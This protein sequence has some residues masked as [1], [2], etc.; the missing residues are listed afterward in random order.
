MTVAEPPARE[1]PTSPR[2]GVV[3]G[4][5]AYVA[6]GLVP[7]YFKQVTGV[8]P[9]AVLAHR[10][11]W[12]VAFLSVLVTVQKLWRE[13]MACF[14]SRSLLLAL[15]GSTFAVAI[16]WFTFIFAISTGRILQSSLGYFMTPLVSVALGVMVL[17][18]R[19]R[20]WQLAG[21]VLVVVG[22]AIQVVGTRQ[23]P[24]ISL[25][26]A[27]SFSSYGL[28]RKQMRVGP[29]IGGIV[30]TMLMLPIAI[31]IVALQLRADV[32]GDAH[33][34][35]TYALLPFSGFVTAIPLLLFARAARSLRLSTMGFLQY[36]SPTGQFLLA[37]AVYHEPISPQ[38]L[39]SFGLIWVALAIYSWDSWRAA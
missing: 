39:A 3:C 25:L 19:L 32:S 17:H 38:K 36:L 1:R 12:S 2:V 15:T 14:R 8:P 11:V 9:I 29:L 5:A 35:R 31:V 33:V 7:L 21:L 22:V 24:W 18:E 10:V 30:E 16:N 4:I 34:A 37:I 27:L 13:V 6:W 20:R 23:I 26:L 28:L